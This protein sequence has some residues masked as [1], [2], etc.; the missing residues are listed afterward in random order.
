MPFAAP[1][2]VVHC[3][4]VRTGLGR[5]GCLALAP[6]LRIGPAVEVVDLP[7]REGQAVDRLAVLLVGVVAQAA[8]DVDVRALT[9]VLG[10][11]LGLVA[12]QRPLDSRGFLFARREAGPGRAQPGASEPLTRRTTRPLSPQGWRLLSG[13]PPSPSGGEDT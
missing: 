13:Q 10:R 8:D 4:P 7:G 9:Q 3:A 1:F 12:P 5:G 2:A 6:R 11:V